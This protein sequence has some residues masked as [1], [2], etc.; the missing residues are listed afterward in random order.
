MPRPNVSF[1]HQVTTTDK[2][3]DEWRW[4]IGGLPTL[5]GWSSAADLFVRSAEGKIAMIDSG[6]GVINVVAESESEFQSQLRNPAK[7]AELLQLDVVEAFVRADGALP[8]DRCL[9]YRTLPALG[10]SY[11]VENR[12]ALSMAEHAAFT[13]DVHRQIRDLPDGARVKIKIVP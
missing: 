5:V 7:A 6:A 11:A 9:G 8:A 2:L 4:L 1:Y 10:G 12:Y 3:L 13:G